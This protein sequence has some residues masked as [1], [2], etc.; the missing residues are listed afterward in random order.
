MRY[1]LISTLIV[2]L[3]ASC[4]AERPALQLDPSH[5]P[6]IS[7]STELIPDCDPQPISLP[8]LPETIPGFAELDDSTGLH[9]T[10]KAPELDFSTYRLQITGLVENPLSLD[11]DQLRC[12]PKVSENP[13]LVC[14]GYF[15]DRANW[16]GVLIDDILRLAQ[17]L[18]QAQNISLVS[19]DGFRMKIDLETAT[20]RESFL[21]YELEGKPLPIL[22]GFPLRAVIPS[23]E[24][25][26]WVK[27]LIEINVQ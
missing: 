21:A 10:G 14:R 6:E 25:N 12:L 26:F 2:V 11:Y 27:W 22:H 18:P 20:D 8:N 19:A 16:S 9:V 17:P 13:L 15:E 3:L 1:I 7:P 23:R 4:Y 24:G 5:Q